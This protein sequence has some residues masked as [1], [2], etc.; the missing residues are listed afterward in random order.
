MGNRS[1]KF[2]IKKCKED[3]R[4]A[5]GQAAHGSLPGLRAGICHPC[6]LQ[7][8][9]R[10]SQRLPVLP[11]EGVAHGSGEEVNPDLGSAWC[12]QQPFNDVV[13]V[14]S[15]AHTGKAEQICLSLNVMF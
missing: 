11:G 7:K 15:C 6:R 12:H 10:C 13:L 8:V 1:D 14:G 3:E 2:F 5:G 9:F 4:R